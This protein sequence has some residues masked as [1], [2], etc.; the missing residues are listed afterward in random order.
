MIDRFFNGLARYIANSPRIKE[1]LH[2][3]AMKRPFFHIWG[4]D[5]P[6]MER[7]W[8]MPMW[9]LKLK[10]KIGDGWMIEYYVPRWKWLPRIRLHIIHRPDE[11]RAL[12]DHPADY[13][14]LV[15]DG[16]Y[17]QEVLTGAR[18]FHPPGTSY[19]AR[20]EHFHR[21]AEVSPGGGATTIFILGPKRQ[22]WGFLVEDRKILNR[23]YFA[24]PQ[25]KQ[26]QSELHHG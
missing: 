2:L 20:A 10:L 3:Y 4:D 25:P 26:R 22:E 16:Y 14:T 21:I 5:G 19:A 6:Y 7:F 12:H 9:A 15:I 1:R 24:V 18:L 11:D 23:D 8:L 17:M 13:R